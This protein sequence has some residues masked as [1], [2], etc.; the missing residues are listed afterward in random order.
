MSS[1]EDR[2]AD[3]G[4]HISVACERVQ[5]DPAEVSVVAVTKTFG[6]EQVR[7]AAEAGLRVFGENR[8]Q[9]AKQK[10]PACP[11]DLEWHMI[12]H[13]QSNKVRDAVRLFSMIHSVD[14]LKLIRAIDNA[15]GLS[16]NAMRVCLEVNVSGE[17]SKYGF[18]PE[19]VPAV[20][21]ESGG[22]INVDVTGLMTIPPFTA[23]PE[24]ARPF[25]RRLRELKDEWQDMCGIPLPELSMGMSHDFEVAVEEGATWVRLGS[26][27]FGDRDEGRPEDK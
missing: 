9:E 16:G 20:L 19:D 25:F 14:S 7:I 3:V 13:L 22:M 27:L 11:G 17:S 18:A 23:D 26:I 5:R 15:C 24:D 10:I 12:G 6:P 2:V 4:R 8:V 1:F 21:E